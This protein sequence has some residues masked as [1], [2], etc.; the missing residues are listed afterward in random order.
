MNLRRTLTVSLVLIFVLVCTAQPANDLQQTAN[1]IASSILLGPSIATLR[2][3][4][5]GI[6][7][8]LTGSPAYQQAA[9]WAAAKFRSYGIRDV[10]Q[11]PFSIQNG[12]QRGL[13][14]G[15][16]LAPLQRPLHVESL[17]WSTSTP[18]GGVQ[19]QVVAVSDLAAEKI[20]AQAGQ[21]KDHI[22]LLDTSKILADGFIKA[23]PLLLASYARLNDAGA[24]AVMFSDHEVDNVLNAHGVAWGAK[25]SPLP[26]VQLGMEDS[27]LIL[28]MLE[29]QP[30]SVKLKLDVQNQVSGPVQVNNVIAEIRGTE[31]PEQW[32]LIGA[33]L[34]SWDAGTGAQ[35][36]GTGS[37]MVLEAARAL[38][39]LALPLRRS[40][41]FALW[42][43]E[44]E[45]LL[46]SYAY[47][48]AHAAEM[49]QCVAVLNT[50]NG[51]G[52]PKGWKVEGRQDLL[53]AMRP[54]S[55]SLLPDLGADDL[56]MEATFDTDH[57]PFLFF[58]IPALDL[59][60]DMSHYM[61]VHHKSSDTFDKVDALNLKTGAAVVAVTAYAI[62]QDPKPI[63][64]H[65]DHAAVAEVIKKTG[66]DELLQSVGVWK[67]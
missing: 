23:L 33:H 17:G 18:A 30:G 14:T 16:M 47:T 21:I 11:E 57:G 46:G 7:G 34:D 29:A 9:D 22:V 6:G 31:H 24:R 41:R 67:P 55:D 25:V 26:V 36:N 49:N 3:L 32:I 40:V 13:T 19:A 58:G 27:K 56:S 37:V 60:V 63:A 59:K 45:G 43:G 66:F 4:S 5:D 12:W 35:D 64:P 44:E 61:E 38:A 62:V 51:A 52:R 54:I 28:R 2:E 42:G 65:L 1:R 20:K 8:R 53:M 50:D 48:Q 39:H 10:R 15:E